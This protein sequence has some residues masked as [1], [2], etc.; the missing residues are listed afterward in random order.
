MDIFEFHFRSILRILTTGIY[1]SQNASHAARAGFESSTGQVHQGKQ[2]EGIVDGQGLSGI[3][4]HIKGF[5]TTSKKKVPL[6]SWRATKLK[7]ALKRKVQMCTTR[8]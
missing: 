8:L 3:C 1:I 4:D 7:G 2:K 5:V 6:K